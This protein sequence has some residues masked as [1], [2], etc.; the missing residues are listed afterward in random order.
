MVT[1]ADILREVIRTLRW[2]GVCGEVMEVGNAAWC[3]VLCADDARILG[4]H[5]YSLAAAQYG[6]EVNWCYS[7]GEVM[8]FCVWLIPEGESTPMDWED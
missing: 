7:R 6:V 5:V 8:A 3:E 1:A 4:H 2:E